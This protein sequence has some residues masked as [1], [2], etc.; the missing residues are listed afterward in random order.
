MDYKLIFKSLSDLVADTS[1]YHKNTIGIERKIAFCLKPT[2]KNQIIEI[3]NIAKK[4]NIKLY[5]ISTGLNWGYGTSNP[6]TNNNVIIDLSK[7][8][9]IIE[10]DSTLNIIT[11]GPG[12]TQEKLY[13]YLQNNNLNYFVPVTGSGPK[14]SIIGNL[15]ERGYGITPHSD[16]FNSLL[17]INA[18]MADGTIYKSGLSDIGDGKLEKCFKWGIGPYIDGLFS[19][20]NFGII[21]DATIALAPKPEK[22]EMFVFRLKENNQ[23]NNV[24]GSIR[25]ILQKYGVNISGIN[26]MNTRRMLSMKTPY[27]AKRSLNDGVMDIHD[28]KK[29][30]KRYYCQ[31]AWTGIGA[32]YGTKATTKAFKKEIKKILKKN[33]SSL[34]FID[35]R[36]DKFLSFISKFLMG[37]LKKSLMNLSKSIQ[38]GM[39]ILEGIPSLVAIPLCYLKNTQDIKITR[40]TNPANDNVGL[41]W[42]SPLVPMKEK[43]VQEFIETVQSICI[44]HNIEPL[45][46]LTT[47]SDKCFDS[48]IPI[49]FNPDSIEDKQ[50]ALKCYN[51]LLEVGKQKG[52]YPYRF[53]INHMKDLT[54][55]DSPFWNICHKI[56]IALDPD[57]II[58]P[59]R[60][61]R[62]IRT[63]EE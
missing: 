27:F 40:D 15:L 22:I 42:Y 39:D 59:G 53:G 31:D 63:N 19:Q 18:I 7:M 1:S 9:Q 23:L 30:A 33:T 57:D 16:H 44:K 62:A 10:F 12:V 20:S 2:N 47:I 28:V 60:Y 11:I 24:I 46:T 38:D 13:K 6:V 55:Q 58:A 3:I 48:T 51:E 29:L 34:I 37:S 43:N 56:K 36:H 26:M 45:I 41:L 49:L 5:P 52:F 54:S 61:N 50:N 4:N 35:R 32:I 8:D 25:E 17:S 21:T 14:S